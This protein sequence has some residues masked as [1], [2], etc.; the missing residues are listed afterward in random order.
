MFTSRHC[1]FAVA[2]TLT[3]VAATA[4]IA[5]AASANAFTGTYDGWTYIQDAAYD[6]TG[7]RHKYEIFGLAAKQ[8]GHQLQVAINANMGL[9]GEYEGRA[10]DNNISFGDLLLKFDQ[11]TYGVRFAPGN[12]SEVTG[13]GVFANITTKD[14]TAAN[15]GWSRRTSYKSNQPDARFYGDARDDAFFGNNAYRS[16]ATVMASGTKVGDISDLNSGLLDFSAAFGGAPVGTD[17]VG[18]AFDLTLAWWG[19]LTPCCCWNVLTMASPSR[20]PPAKC[21]SP[22]V[23]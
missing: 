19:N 9:A 16:T 12:D 4:L 23:S 21:R 11:A 3:T 15:A 13:T 8:V 5:P 14:V 22:L 18:F 7:G 17:T 20:R 10:A 6:S 1:A 2:S